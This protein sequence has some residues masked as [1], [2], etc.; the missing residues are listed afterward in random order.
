MFLLISANPHAIWR[1]EFLSYGIIYVYG[2]EKK[3]KIVLTYFG[4][5]WWDKTKDWEGFLVLA[6][7]EIT[8]CDCSVM[9]TKGRTVAMA[10][11]YLSPP[12]TSYI[13]Q[14]FMYENRNNFTKQKSL[15]L[16][17]TT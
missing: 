5:N 14:L 8:F 13:E 9:G 4:D 7:S 3:T 15:R 16:K 10:C 1:I 17:L 12:S 11:A 6:N 2:N